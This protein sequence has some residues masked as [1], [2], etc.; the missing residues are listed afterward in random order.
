MSRKTKQRA[1][2]AIHPARGKESAASASLT[3]I[4]A[5]SFPDAVFLRMSRKHMIAQLK[6]LWIQFVKEDRGGKSV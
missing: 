1:H 3:T 6:R 4:G 2:A 5:V